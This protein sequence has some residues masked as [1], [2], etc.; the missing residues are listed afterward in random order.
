M[1]EIL[2]E[3][4]RRQQPRI[5]RLVTAPFRLVHSWLK[6]G[7]DLIAHVFPH[8]GDDLV[9]GREQLE[10]DRLSKAT[11]HLLD[12]WRSQF[13]AAACEGGVLVQ[14]PCPDAHTVLDKSPIPEPQ[15]EWLTAVRS[16][17]AAW[18]RKHPWLRNTLPVATDTLVIGGFGL[19]V[20]D[21]FAAGGLFGG[22]VLIGNLGLAGAAAGGGG[23]A[24]LLLK[25]AG[26]WRPSRVTSW[27]PTSVAHPA[28]A[29]TDRG[30]C[31]CTWPGRC[32]GPGASPCR[33][34]QASPDRGLRASLCG[35][36]GNS[37]AKL[38]SDSCGTPSA[39]SP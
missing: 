23:A 22:A 25:W 14:D 17:V 31:G 32:S 5:L 8:A 15:E 28:D 4:V 6:T 35:H 19:L 18:A 26:K 36:R 1:M 12:Q 10:A 29:G 3:E 20:L 33:A 21:L 11:K 34:P 37:G 9:R 30:P 39:S 27:R 7:K 38:S 13:P 2:F 16:A 24:G